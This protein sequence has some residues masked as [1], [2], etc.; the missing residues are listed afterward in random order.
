M[1]QHPIA[2]QRQ[3]DRVDF[4]AQRLVIVFGWAVLLTLAILIWHL[5]SQAL[6]LF[7]SPSLKHIEDIRLPDNETVL[8]IGD[9]ERGGLLI[10]RAEDC[11]VHYYILSVQKSPQ[12]IKRTPYACD[13]HI[14]VDSQ[15]PKLYLVEYSAQNIIRAHQI[16]SSG[17]LLNL[18]L[19]LS[20]SLPS[21]P[22]HPER[23]SI[24]LHSKW[25][26]LQYADQ[27]RSNVLWVN[28]QHPTQTFR[29][30]APVEARVLPMPSANGS[31]VIGV[32]GPTLW[33]MHSPLE[34]DAVKASA[35]S[36]LMSSSDDRAVYY[37]EQQGLLSKWA[38]RNNAGVM[39]LEPTYILSLNEGEKALS[40]HA[41]A[42]V[43][44]GL[45]TTSSNRIV[46]FNR[47]TGEILHRYGLTNQAR[48][49]NWY[50]DHLYINDDR[51][52][53]VW[54]VRNRAS[55]TTLSSLF[56][57]QHYSGYEP[58]RYVWQTTNAKD[59]QLAK[60]SLVPMI[61]GSLKAS[62]VALLIAIPV[63]LG[64]AIYTA[65]FAPAQIRAWIKPTVEMLEAIPSV[66]IGFIA[67]V[68]LAPMADRFLVGVF[69]FF[70]ITPIVLMISTFFQVQI[71][72]KLP[73]KIRL[74]WELPFVSL[75]LIV[76]ASA[77]LWFG[78]ESLIGI[79]TVMGIPFEEWLTNTQISKTALV[80][81]VALGLAISPT[82]FSLADDAID[83]VPEHLKKAS[84]ALGATQLQT[85]KNV[86]LKVALP[87]IIAAIML[88]LG[89]AFGETMI[90]LMVTGNTP[91]AD[92]DIFAGLRALTAN[93]AIE[94]PESEVGS[95][96]YRVLFL[97]ACLLFVFTFVINTV[98][99]LLR[100]KA[101]KMGRTA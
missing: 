25:A 11:A 70:L 16:S 96:H 64:A 73:E 66:V 12:R 10:T 88:G 68:W 91:V 26:A 95:A 62:V 92:W 78:L 33:Q 71:A 6:P 61:I 77:S 65:Y 76:I 18:E 34:N 2:R 47:L 36:R 42:S 15:L 60:Y 52:V 4:I 53:G 5:A 69:L 94:L 87:G 54:A 63:A 38:L 93:L 75:T 1:L 22:A 55:T 17:S 44:L 27:S 7:Q 14:F 30:I 98:A 8:H 48:T 99:E 67:A 50:G 9:I 23:M 32:S 21:K 31:A 59:F 28:R 46:L 89:R 19:V 79:S 35:S 85:L 72:R 82:V 13:S 101:R 41:D 56:S 29:Q 80:V 97:T 45:I 49:V 86:V 57:A 3:R 81:A 100:K 58:D 51:V 37:A 74:I 20:R 43:N 90:V 24:V 84:F 39:T 83:S 40:V